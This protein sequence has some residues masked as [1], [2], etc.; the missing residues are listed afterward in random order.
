[1]SPLYAAEKIKIF[2][3]IRWSFMS[4]EQLISCSK[5]KDFELAKNFILEGL[6]MRLTNFEIKDDDTV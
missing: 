3:A 5:D 6:S 1:M 4:H 2:K